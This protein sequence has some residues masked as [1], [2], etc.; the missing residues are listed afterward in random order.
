M[1]GADPPEAANLKGLGKIFN[2]VTVAGRA[3]VAKATYASLA[4][5]IA[6]LALKPSKKK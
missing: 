2:S 6:Y 4:V 1:A 5:L 3:N